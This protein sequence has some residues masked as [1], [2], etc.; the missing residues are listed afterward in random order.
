MARSIS[1]H[2]SVQSIR[3]SFPWSAKVPF[4]Q[5]GRTAHSPAPCWGYSKKYNAAVSISVKANGSR[6]FLARG[7]GRLPKT[8]V[9]L[10]CIDTPAHPCV[11][12]RTGTNSIVAV[13]HYYSQQQFSLAEKQNSPNAQLVGSFGCLNIPA[14]LEEMDVGSS[15]P[16]S[17]SWSNSFTSVTFS[18]AW[19]NKCSWK[20]HWCLA[21]H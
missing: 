8:R 9:L 18:C 14:A 1:R 10:N 5:T 7:C 11:H 2:H 12:G 13:R 15:G 6:S 4:V 19:R 20:M 21:L 3:T 17:S 16:G